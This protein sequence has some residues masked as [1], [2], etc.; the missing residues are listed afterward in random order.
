MNL[1]QIRNPHLIYPGQILW[2]EIVDGRARLRL[3]RRISGSEPWLQPRVRVDL[4]GSTDRCSA[5]EPD[6]AVCPSR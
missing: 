3:G 6:R 2:L 4:A 5:I 1:Q